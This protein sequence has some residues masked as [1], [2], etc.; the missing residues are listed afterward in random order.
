MVL[1][2]GYKFQVN[3]HMF[4]QIG[5]KF[6][7]NGHMFLQIGHKFRVNVRM[8]P[9]FGLYELTNIN[10]SKENPNEPFGFSFTNTSYPIFS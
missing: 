1:R 4:L 6:W 10:Y 2:I 5:H 7:I 3:G 9:R 8:V